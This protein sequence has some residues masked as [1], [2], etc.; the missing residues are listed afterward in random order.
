MINRFTSRVAVVAIAVALAGCV[1]YHDRHYDERRGPPSH[2]RS[3]G[4]D[5]RVNVPPGHMPPPGQCRIWYPERP[6]GQQPPPGDC[7]ELRHRV[8]HDAALI[9]GR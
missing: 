5:A 1:A 3:A 7:R 4:P 6:P 9:Y 8:P 2:A